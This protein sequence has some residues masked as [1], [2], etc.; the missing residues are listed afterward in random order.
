[1]QTL[2]IE[3]V[4][5][6][7]ESIKEVILKNKDY[8]IELDSAMGDGD[9][10]LTMST[11][12]TAIVDEL[13][14]ISETDIGAAVMKLGMVMANAVPS[15]MGTLVATAIMR[16][17]KVVKGSE[18]ITL[19]EMIDMGDAAIEG[20]M[21]RGKSKRGEKTILDALFPGVEGLKSVYENNGD[22]KAAAK[23]AYDGAAKG[24]AETKNMKSIHGRA[25]WYAEKSIGHQDPGATVG[26]LLFEGINNYISK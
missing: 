14:K 4:K 17:G 21:Q 22:L 24:A 8:L 13:P 10:G 6:T 26:M 16:A 19:K 2:K 12:F 11:G 15:T 18:E 20:I 25:G 3:D 23:A 9:L 7:F 1:M 5:K